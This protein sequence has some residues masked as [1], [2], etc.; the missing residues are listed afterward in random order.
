[1]HQHIREFFGVTDS[2]L[3]YVGA[4]C[5][6]CEGLGVHKRR[7]VYELMV[8]TPRLQAL[9]VPGAQ[10]DEINRVAIEQGM[11]PITQAALKLARA[12]L[13]SLSEAW[14]VRAD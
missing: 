9:I 8:I 10:A 3:F 13:I 6:H 7:A 11:V 4:G 5:S 12:G 1:M 14:R 2:E